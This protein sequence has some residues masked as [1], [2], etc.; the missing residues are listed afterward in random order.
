MATYVCSDVHGRFDLFMQLL[1]TIQFN[2]NDDLYILGDAIDRH[3]GSIEIL[4]YIIKNPNIHLIMG[5]HE[6]M[7]LEVLDSYFNNGGYIDYYDYPWFIAC[8]GGSGTFDLFKSESYEMQKLIYK[9]LSDAPYLVT[10]TIG[11]QKFHLS[12]TGTFYG[13]GDEKLQPDTEWY[14]SD[15]STDDIQFLTWFSPY[16]YKDYIPA[17]YYPTDYLSI[18]GHISVQELTGGECIAYPHPTASILTIDGGLAN[19]NDPNAALIGIKINDFTV[20]YIK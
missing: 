4:K 1:D 6:C 10:L 18:N 2:K 12:H 15:L 19:S 16:T 8:N 7:M 13:D 17:E 9:L 11:D 20:N 5:N 14:A 3:D